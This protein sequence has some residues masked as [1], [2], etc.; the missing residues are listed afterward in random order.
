MLGC[1]GEFYGALMKSQKTDMA[2]NIPS[3]PFCT[4][5]FA[6]DGEH[7]IERVGND[8]DVEFEEEA[9]K[10]ELNRRPQSSQRLLADKESSS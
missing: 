9:Y 3:V 1:P 10:D 4:R 7:M 6:T 8:S 5:Q 2:P